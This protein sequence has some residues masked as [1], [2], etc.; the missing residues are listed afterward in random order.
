MNLGEWIIKRL[1]LIRHIYSASKQVRVV[2]CSVTGS[3]SV[4]EDTYIMT[5]CHGSRC[6]HMVCMPVV[7]QRYR[8]FSMCF[9]YRECSMCCGFNLCCLYV[10]Q[11]M[12]VCVCVCARTQVSAALNPENESTKAFQ[13]CVIIKHPRQGEYAFGFITGRTVVQVSPY[14]HTHTHTQIHT[15]L[16]TC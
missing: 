4:T 12:C 3:Q 2:G 1:P 16:R 6:V 11:A 13:E 9:G 8:E 14:K 5:D 10:P 15:H 7:C